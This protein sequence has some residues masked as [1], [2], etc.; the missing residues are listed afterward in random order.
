LRNLVRA[1]DDI[2]FR[3]VKGTTGTQASFLALFNG[4][5]DKVLLVPSLPTYENI[6]DK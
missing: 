1:R 3:G 4:D 5:H 6:A 2:G